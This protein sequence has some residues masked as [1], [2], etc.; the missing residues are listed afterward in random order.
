M[1]AQIALLGRL[2]GDPERRTAASGTDW[3]S[4]SIA[5][6]LNDSRT[7]DGAPTWMKIVAFGRLAETICRHSKGDLV[8]ICGR[9][10]MSRWKTAEG[11]DPEQLQILVDSIVSAKSVRPGGGRKLAEA[12][13]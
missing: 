12:A 5:A 6:D 7:E 3:W 13:Q 2:G 9:L 10:Q 11:V 8:A 1:N 4:A